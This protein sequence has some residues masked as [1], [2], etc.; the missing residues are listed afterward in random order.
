MRHLRVSLV[1][2]SE[3]ALLEEVDHHL[4][5]AEVLL[6]LPCVV[7]VVPA[8]PLDQEQVY[9]LST[10]TRITAMELLVVL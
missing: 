1:L 8:F 10:D 5:A 9:T 2:V 6:R 3:F 4:E 7:G